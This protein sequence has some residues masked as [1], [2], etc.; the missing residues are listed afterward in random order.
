MICYLRRLC[1]DRLAGQIAMLILVALVLF[2]FVLT[3]LQTL[4][5]R[6]GRLP[7]PTVYEVLSS[8]ILAVDLAPPERREEALQTLAKTAHWSSLRIVMA[9]PAEWRDANFRDDLSEFATRLWP[10]ARVYLA[11]ETN[12]RGEHDVVVALRQGDYLI[13]AAELRRRPPG[14]G[15]PWPLRVQ[16]MALFFLLSVTLLTVWISSAVVAPLVRLAREAERFPDESGAMPP[17][18]EAGPREVRDLTR[19]VNRMQR[20]IEAMIAARSQAL[21]AISHDLR[22]ILT[23]IKLRSE[24]IGD[25]G[26]KSKMLAD[27]DL[28]DS[29]LLKNLQALR[30]GGP[31]PDRG[32]IDLDSV[33]Q[34]VC[35]QFADLGH[36]VSYNGGHH[37][38]ILGSLTELQRVFT[39]LVENAVSHAQEV[40]VTLSQ[41]SVKLVQVDVTDDGPG[42]PDAEKARVLE[43]FVRGE[44]ARTVTD[45]SGFG[46]GLSIV[47]SLVR[48]LGG[49][50]ELIDR[51]PRGLI[52]RVTLPRAFAGA[53]VSRMEPVE[54]AQRSGRVA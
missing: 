14:A 52:A 19:A 10:G 26:L 35:D 17:L 2:Q 36:K 15:G 51:Q 32:P 18:A 21:A 43:P 38:I 22:T 3:G 42:I 23:R 8:A 7:F 16:R 33:L 48:E 1:P 45:R 53:P 6:N 49:R 5:T 30:D 27:A 24:F 4:E 20:R 39:N 34:T 46:L 31:S 37:Q 13:A 9:P 28:M 47:R 44:P 41:P 54:I 12:A 50:L 29:M 40:V 11:Q 25:E